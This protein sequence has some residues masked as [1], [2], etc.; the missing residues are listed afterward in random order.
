MKK[1][2]LELFSGNFAPRMHLGRF[3]S[4]YRIMIGLVVQYPLQHSTVPPSGKASYFWK[5]LCRREEYLSQ[6]F[7][8]GLSTGSTCVSSSFRS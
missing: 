3:A 5:D 1:T 6:I 4:G 7:K 8:Y 2:N